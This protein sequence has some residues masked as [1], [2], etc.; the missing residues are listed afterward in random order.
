MAKYKTIS[1]FIIFYYL[2]TFEKCFLF[3]VIIPIYNT[4]RYLD[5]SIGSII[6]QTIGLKN[7]Q[8]ILVNDGSTDKTEEIC[9]NYQKKYNKN[10]I[11]IKIEHSGVSKARNIGMKYA[12]GTYINFLD[13][14]DKWDY[15]AF[16]HILLFFQINKNINYVAGRIK[17]FEALNIYHPLDYKFYKTRIVNL[18]QEYNCIQL[19]ASS[20]VFR[21]TI[22]EGK[23]FMENISFSEDTRLINNILL[24]NPIMGVIKEALYYYRKRDDFSS[25]VQNKADKLFFYFDSINSVFKYFIDFSKNLYNKI[26]PFIQFLISYELLYR[27]QTP[28]Y[29][30]LNSDNFNKYIILIDDILNQIEDKYILEQKILSNKH[31]LFLLSKKY[32]RDLRYEIKFENNSFFY[33]KYVMINIKID[34]SIFSLR[35][36]NIKNSKL[37][38]EALDNFWMPRENYFYFCKINN[39]IFFQDILKTQ[40]II[41]LQC[42]GL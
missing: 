2:L 19:Q 20:S 5:D 42:M 14:D 16:Y 24:V 41:F 26:L 11:Y 8:I 40:N 23:Y 1:L 15:Q 22:L 33:S 18:S 17:F 28:S 34:K 32:H 3:S 29:K 21:K 38:L 36:L 27:I 13:S 9:L 31:K 25:V 6:N 4:G 37:Y 12:N 30:Y 7:I 39:K 35:K 10:I